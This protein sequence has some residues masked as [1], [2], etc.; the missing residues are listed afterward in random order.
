MRCHPLDCNG[1]KRRRGPADSAVGA[2]AHPGAPLGATRLLARDHADDEGNAP[3]VRVLE[4]WCDTG[5]AG[6]VSYRIPGSPMPGCRRLW[7]VLLVEGN[8]AFKG[9]FWP[10][11]SPFLETGS[12]SEEGRKYYRRYW[13]CVLV[14]IGLF[15]L[16]AFVFSLSEYGIF[17]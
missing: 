5:P 15:I 6:M 7:V 14:A 12:L 2:L 1:S 9:F 8:V 4:F 11:L 16:I 17:R 13:F 3:Q 10:S